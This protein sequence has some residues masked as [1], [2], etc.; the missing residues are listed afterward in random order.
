MVLTRWGTNQECR[1]I[2]L[3]NTSDIEFASMSAEILSGTTVLYGYEMGASQLDG[4]AVQ[5]KEYTNQDEITIN[6]KQ[7]GTDEYKE[8]YFANGQQLG[9]Y[10]RDESVPGAR[11]FT[12]AEQQT[13]QDLATAASSLYNNAEGQRLYELIESIDFQDWMI[14]TFGIQNARGFSLTRSLRWGE[15]KCLL[16]GLGNPVCATVTV[17]NTSLFFMEWLA[18]D[19]IPFFG[20][21]TDGCDN[22]PSWW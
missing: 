3:K 14:S 19:V 16:G 4:T 7:T 17:V 18:C 13:C 8:T 1:W 5:F 2:K 11:S 10:T 20:G 6:D 22:L 9:Q 15:V 12:A 21:P